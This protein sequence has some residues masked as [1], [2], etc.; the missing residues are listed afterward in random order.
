MILDTGKLLKV[1]MTNKLYCNKHISILETNNNLNNSR[2]PEGLVIAMLGA[3]E[4]VTY[5]ERLT[6]GITIVDVT[7]DIAVF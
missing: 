7:N 5:E 2:Q 6:A 1:N 4:S 3:E